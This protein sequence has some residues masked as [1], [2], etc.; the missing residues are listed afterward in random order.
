M[1][2]WDWIQAQFIII[3]L[4]S[5]RTAHHRTRFTSPDYSWTDKTKAFNV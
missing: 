3:R 5:V 2:T 1:G 4:H